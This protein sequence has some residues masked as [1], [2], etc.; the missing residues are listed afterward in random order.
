MPLTIAITG[1]NGLV[2]QGVT[3]A[4]LLAGHSVIALDVGPESTHP[5]ALKV[6]YHSLDA[7]DFEAYLGIL[8]QEEVDAVVHLAAVYNKFDKDGKYLTHVPS[9]VSGLDCRA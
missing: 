7:T 6:K 1:A 5:E 4:A 3:S 8:K 9:H 2:G